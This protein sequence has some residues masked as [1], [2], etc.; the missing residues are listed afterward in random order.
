ML[1]PTPRTRRADSLATAASQLLDELQVPVPGYAV[2]VLLADGGR[3][4]TAEHLGRAATYER[5]A[6]LRTLGVPS[7]CWAIDPEARA[8]QPRWYA[9]GDWR[10]NR[11]ILTEDVASLWHSVLAAHI[12]GDLA[13]RDRPAGS[14]ITTLAMWAVARIGLQGHFDVPMSRDDWAALRYRIGQEKPGTFG[15]PSLATSQQ[16]AAEKRLSEANLPA[17]D[18]LFGA[19]TGARAQR[20]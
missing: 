3:P 12:C 9:G 20:V 14:E 5:D 8:I 10:L 18:L 13:G 15:S 19:G 17:A 2:R 1:M 7:F 4:V 11:R 6:Y 16:H